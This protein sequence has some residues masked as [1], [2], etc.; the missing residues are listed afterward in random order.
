MGLFDF[1]FTKKEQ[2]VRAETAFR[3]LT[4]YAPHF[5]TW[6]GC[7]YENELVRASVDAIARHFSKL[8]VEFHGAAQPSMITRLRQ[9]PNEWST[10]SQFLYRTATILNVQ[11]NCVIVPVLNRYGE[12]VG[13]YPVVPDKCSVKEYAGKPYLRFEFGLQYR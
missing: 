8:V 4:A 11:D 2:N 10:W 13:I 3:T 5:T 1:L 6:D 12:T 9:Q 7:V